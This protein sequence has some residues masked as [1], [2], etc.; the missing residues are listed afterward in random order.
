[1]A[2][3]KVIE[4]IAESTTSWEDATEQAIHEASK[5]IKNIKSVYIKEMKASVV[6]NKV[7]KYLIIAKISFQVND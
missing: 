7:D 5:T 1:M 4:V 6:N 3:I 2:I